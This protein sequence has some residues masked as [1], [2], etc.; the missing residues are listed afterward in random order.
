MYNIM[1][2]PSYRVTKSQC[3]EAY[4]GVNVDIGDTKVCAGR[5]GTDTCNGEILHFT[6]REEITYLQLT[7]Q[8]KL[9]RLD[10]THLKLCDQV[11]RAAPCWRTAWALGG[12][13]WG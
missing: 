10:K 9:G 8:F 1:I 13:W 2:L 5:G 4:S 12:A 11:T 7:K 3:K 6:Y